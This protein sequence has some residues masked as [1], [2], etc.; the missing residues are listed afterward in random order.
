MNQIKFLFLNKILSIFLFFILAWPN[1]VYSKPNSCEETLFDKYLPPEEVIVTP[2]NMKAIQDLNIEDQKKIRKWQLKWA[3]NLKA[4]LEQHTHLGLFRSV[5]GFPQVFDLKWFILHD[6]GDKP[7]EM[8][9]A[10]D[11]VEWVRLQLARENIL[12]RQL[13]ILDDKLR[14]LESHN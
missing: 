10:F 2:K 1:M 4:E 14:E 8:R 7:L 13:L 6:K 5:S 9:A 12:N 11:F 3:K